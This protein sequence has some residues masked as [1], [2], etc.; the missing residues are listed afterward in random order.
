L[1]HNIDRVKELVRSSMDSP[2][3]RA[4]VVVTLLKGGLYEQ[5]LE[6][7]LPL[8]GTTHSPWFLYTRSWHY[9]SRGESQQAFRVL[10]DAYKSLDPDRTDEGDEPAGFS[11]NSNGQPRLTSPFSTPLAYG[12][13]SE[14]Q[15][16]DNGE[17][18]GYA[19]AIF[20]EDWLALFEDINRN[21][22][23]Y[24]EVFASLTK[25]VERVIHHDSETVR[26]AVA[27]AEFDEET[28]YRENYFLLLTLLSEEH[29]RLVA[30]TL[31]RVTSDWNNP[32][33]LCEVVCFLFYLLEEDKTAMTLAELGLEQDRSSVVCG[34]IRA[35]ILN[36]SGRPYM[37][38]EQWRETLALSPDRSATY[39]VLGHQAL[40]TG[41]VEPAL[42]YFQEALVVGDNPLEAERFLTA[43]IECVDDDEG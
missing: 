10:T 26:A 3:F 43:A 11:F 41:G 39:L 38:D 33:D 16:P 14:V 20:H 7:S 9:L 17:H 12:N 23:E 25:C 19:N 13:G 15:W 28:N 5:A 27:S 36:D 1:D 37:A 24:K 8:V 30:D 32:L 40:C 34:N 18:L 21:I 29:L 2:E 22:R 6:L 31:W 35:C 4:S 42:R